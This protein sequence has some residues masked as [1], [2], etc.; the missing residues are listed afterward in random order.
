MTKQAPTGLESPYSVYKA[1][2]WSQLHLLI[3]DATRSTYYMNYSTHLNDDLWAEIFCTVSTCYF[4][5][6]SG[7]AGCLFYELSS[8]MRRIPPSAP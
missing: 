2:R 4:V 8:L 7:F 6:S 3:I 5:C 1:R